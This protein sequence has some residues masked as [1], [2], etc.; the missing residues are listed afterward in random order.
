[1]KCTPSD[2]LLMSNPPK[3]KCKVCG[4]IW[5][6]GFSA[7][8]CGSNIIPNTIKDTGD[9]AKSNEYYCIKCGRTSNV[10]KLDEN[11]PFCMPNTIKDKLCHCA[12][13]DRYHR[14]DSNYTEHTFD[15]CWSI[16]NIKDTGDTAKSWEGKF[17]EGF[18]IYTDWIE[19]NLVGKKTLVGNEIKDF[20]R[21]LLKEQRE[22]MFRNIKDY[23]FKE[24]H[25][26]GFNDGKQDCDCFIAGLNVALQIIKSKKI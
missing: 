6:V 16:K 21:T 22:D 25:I 7:P 4:N 2:F 8:D 17:D 26:C 18:K 12:R 19:F 11:C 20:I 9:T 3:H 10:V 23:D 14:Q 13:T 24:K 5:T 15:K 1:M